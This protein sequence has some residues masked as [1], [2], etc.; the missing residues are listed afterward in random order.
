MFRPWT[1]GGR[2]ALWAS[3]LAVTIVIA[4]QT[5]AFAAPTAQPTVTT[6]CAT[7]PAV[8]PGVVAARGSVPGVYGGVLL[9]GRQVDAAATIV[10]AGLDA[11]IS[12]RGIAVAVAAAMAASS[13]N[14]QALN[15]SHV[16]LFQQ[17][18]DASSGLYT[19]KDRGD[20][21]AAT[22]MFFA[23]LTSRVPG[24]DTDARSNSDLGDAVQESGDVAG[25]AAWSA[26]A[27]GLVDHFIPVEAPAAVL[28]APVVTPA[29]VEVRADRFG[30][31]GEPVSFALRSAGGALAAAPAATA[32]PAPSE[33]PAVNT[34]LT[35]TAT[36]AGST[37]TGSATGS[38]T[39]STTSAAV[40]TGSTAT[41][42]TTGSATESTTSA[43]VTTGSTTTDPTTTDPTTTAPVTTEPSSADPSS[44]DP[45]S[46]GPSVEP[47]TTAPS[48]ESTTTAP[49]VEPTSSAPIV[50]PTTTAPVTTEPTTP[51][52]VEPRLGTPMLVAP[53]V[54]DVPVE[55][56]IAPEP[57]RSSDMGQP[58]GRVAVIDCGPNN[59]GGSTA[60]DPGFIVS[61]EVFYNSRAMAPEQVQA[62]L[63]AQGA[64]CEGASCVK[65]LRVTTPDVPADQ[66]CS[67]YT[68]GA[69][70][71]ASAVLARASV[72][73]GINPQ[74]MLVTLQKESA[75]LTRSSVSPASYTAAWG[76][77]CPDSGPGGAANCDPAY[78]GFFNQ[79][80]GMAKQWARYRVDP[81]KYHY[82][83]GETT[84][85]LWN[86]AETGCGGTDVTIRNTATAS[87]YNYTPYQPNAA[88]LASYPSVGDRCSAYGNR[89]FF[90]LFQKYFGV[91]GGGIIA[92][93]AVN[94][95]QVT[96]PDS[97]S[98]APEVR[99][100]VITAPNESVARGLA[101]GF[102]S[103][104]LPYVWGGGTNG[105]QAD[106]GCS[107]GGTAKNSCGGTVG[108][109]CSGLTAYVLTT[110][111]FAVG[112]NSG[113]QRAGGLS[114]P[115]SAGQ[116]GDLIGY[117]G[118]VAV[119][120]GKINGVDYLLEAPDVNK[121]VQIRAVY[122]RSSGSSADGMLHRYWG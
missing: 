59:N 82:R 43:A 12:R 22:Q 75:L 6:V 103:V 1:A 110:A 116:P 17:H 113:S 115:W 23:E 3:A 41:G 24:Y 96:I 70:E 54:V 45:S 78:A 61:D 62:F 73:C 58:T 11:G 34:P 35:T 66:Y 104:G 26:L 37:T 74:V 99:G 100:A 14:P 84:N 46:T 30:R 64:A 21:V 90:F 50:D 69:D 38:T 87:L 92:T 51:A 55:P 114:V 32:D 67:A 49:G 89:N 91:T 53:P 57:V 25:L 121:F 36:A 111:G 109:D 79:M 52:A 105:G 85:I 48:V 20:A 72:A 40:T 108:F 65:N 101:V 120:L 71:L 122:G 39:E 80:F 98:V 16:G 56:D 63:D 19:T 4:G 28:E 97:P 88:A 5:P 60:F 112:T 68:G 44:T 15:A 31:R 42:S 29:T 8:P 86:V 47:T 118:H 102:A 94:G 10:N 81:D 9:T 2:R 83:A 18:A 7:T 117:S 93:V 77:H 119:Y 107:R 76:W 33:P 106:Q 13:L 95:V 27:D